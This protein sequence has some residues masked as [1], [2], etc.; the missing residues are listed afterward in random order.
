MA[1]EEREPEDEAAEDASGESHGKRRTGLVMGG[2]ALA[3]IATAGIAALLA[4]PSKPVQKSFA[5]PFVMSLSQ[6]PQLQVNLA[7][8]GNKRFLV[9][10]LKVE[11]DAYDQAYG[12]GRIADPLYSARLQDRLLSI[13]SQ[14]TSDEV[15]DR[16]TQEL[17]LR[18]I[19]QAVE[20]LLFPIHVGETAHH[21][22]RDEKSGLRPGASAA[23]S[24]MRSPLHSRSL[25]VDAPARTLRLGDG[26]EVRFEG[27]EED[28]ELVDADGKTVH[29]DVTGL[30]PEFQ[31]S[32]PV[33]VQGRL[34]DVYKV[35][36][37]V[38]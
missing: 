27:T 3:L 24:T 10:I 20:P 12:Q 29:V 8:Q 5:G 16:A 6:E 13:A 37:I 14:K 9:M 18:E 19:E 35:K 30:K 33:G 36:F 2:G 23:R 38:Q 17:F 7:G 22:Q 4:V 32:V 25:H 1:D 26:A 15:L 34:R 28:L 31:G 11:F 21:T